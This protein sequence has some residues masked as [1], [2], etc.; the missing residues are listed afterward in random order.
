MKYIV[1]Y[2]G[3][4]ITVEAENPKQARHKAYIKFNESYPTQYGTFM[5]GIEEV[6]EAN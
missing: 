2:N 6:S 1:S 5:R 4:G 3:W